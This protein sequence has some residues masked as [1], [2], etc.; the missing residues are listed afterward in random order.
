MV[1]PLT[2]EDA[3]QAAAKHGGECLSQVY[4]NSKSH[5]HWRCQYNHEWTACLNKV[6]ITADGVP[7]VVEERN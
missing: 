1:R 6:R 5:L 3:R 2:I 7:I 4:V